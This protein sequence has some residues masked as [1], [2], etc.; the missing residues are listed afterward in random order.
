MAATGLVQVGVLLKAHG[1][2]GECV[3]ALNLE[4]PK[5]LL[6]VSGL[7]V[8]PPGSAVPGPEVPP[9]SWPAPTKV[10]GLR[11]H[12]GRQLLRLTGVTD[13]TRAEQ[14]RGSLLCI[15]AEDLP[16]SGDDAIYCREL[17]GCAVVL[18]DGRPLGIVRTVLAPTPEQEIWSIETPDGREVLFPA[19]PQTVLELDMAAR[20]LRIAPPEG[21]LELYLGADAPAV[22]GGATAMGDSASELADSG[23]PSA[24]S[25]GPGRP[26]RRGVGKVGRFGRGGKSRKSRAVGT[27]ED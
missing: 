25:D 17:P 7:Y 23:V 4:E 15:P 19:H 21:L 20:R 6:E 18:E 10:V 11:E 2:R 27:A 26:G 3:A 12:Q 22:T 9:R 1:I 5:L 24:R 14:L 16:P 13:R 8:L